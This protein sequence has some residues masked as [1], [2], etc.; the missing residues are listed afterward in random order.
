MESGANA[1]TVTTNIEKMARAFGCTLVETYCQ[2][3]AIIV[4]LQR[5]DESLSHMTKVGEHGVNLREGEAVL[6]IVDEI[7]EGRL[8]WVEA[9]T[10]LNQIPAGIHR[11]PK[12][13]VCGATGL[14][15]AAFGRLLGME[16]A[17]FGP[18][19][20]GAAAGQWVRVAMLARG[21][22]FYFMVATVAFCAAAMAGL[23]GRMLGG[24]KLEIAT[25]AA[26]LLLVP[27]PAMLNSQIDALHGKPNLAVA[28]MFRIGQIFIFLTLGLVAAQRLI[29]MQS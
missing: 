15:C 10:R 5:G 23:G 17:S 28:R 21:M 9:E 8:D 14:A 26:T 7:E 6:H 29:G 20:A 27:G 18:V 3:S 12:W 22:N 25:V 11:Y 13:L 19:L 1:G 4:M 24:T 16:W 2:H